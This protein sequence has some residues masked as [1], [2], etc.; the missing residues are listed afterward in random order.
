MKGVR[1][2]GNNYYYVFDIKDGSGKRK[3]KK[4]RG[5]KTK[6]EA[7]KALIE[8]MHA[9]NTGTYIEPSKLTYKDYC[10]QWY[11]AKRHT[12]GA[13][14][15]KVYESCLRKRIKPTLG[16]L[17]MAKLTPL[18][19]QTFL[20]SLKEE[21]L[22]HSTIKKHLEIIKGSLG[23]AVE[24]KLI[25]SNPASKVKIPKVKKKEKKVWSEEEFLSFLQHAKEDPCYIVF[26]LAITTGMRQGEILGLRWRDL[27]FDKRI[28]SIR[29]T[30]SQ[31]EKSFQSEAKTEASIRTIELSEYTMESLKEQKE[32]IERKKVEYGVLYQDNDLIACTRHGTPFNPSNIRRSFDRLIKKA[33]VPKIRFHDLRHTHA[34]FLLSK[35]LNV[36]MV[37]ERLGHSNIKVTLDFYSKVLPTMQKEAVQVL[38]QVLKKT[39]RDQNVT[40]DDI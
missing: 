18:I 8:A 40:K 5:F 36:K 34:T 29:Q 39:P 28:L 2:E 15:K 6:T 21:G 22:S 20:N 3:Q 31:D 32:F 12:I 37:S 19:I 27:N 13:Q 14:S 1:K 30:W 4:K 24:D 7:K 23:Q 11:E 9:V 16:N 33:S 25:P 10:D 35:K 26:E 17:V 38:D